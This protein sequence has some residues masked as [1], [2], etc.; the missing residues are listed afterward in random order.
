MSTGPRTANHPPSPVVASNTVF[1]SSDGEKIAFAFA[2]EIQ[3]RNF[4][5]V[6]GP[7]QLLSLS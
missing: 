1:N 7:R 5:L 2:F 3:V 4:H 6:L